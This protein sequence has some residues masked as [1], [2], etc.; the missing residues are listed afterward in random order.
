MVNIRVTSRAVELLKIYYLRKLG[1]FKKTLKR[2]KLIEKYL[3]SQP[4]NIVLQY[5]E[6][7]AVK[8]FIGRHML[9]FKPIFRA[10]TCQ[11]T[12]N[13]DIFQETFSCTLASSAKRI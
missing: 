1:N 11:K 2:L 10:V 8:Y 4:K 6:K 7:L 13:F 12:P 5:W 3:P 9:L